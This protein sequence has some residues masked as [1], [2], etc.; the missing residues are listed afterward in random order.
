MMQMNKQGYISIG[1]GEKM[2]DADIFT[3]EITSNEN[4]ILKDTY[5]SG[6][7]APIIDS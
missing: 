5:S 4:V 7:S 2:K 3:A 6:Y 1:I